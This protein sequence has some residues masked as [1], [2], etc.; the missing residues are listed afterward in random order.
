MRETTAAPPTPKINETRLKLNSP[1]KSHTKEPIIVSVNAMIVVI[2]I[3]SPLASIICS[4]RDF[5]SEIYFK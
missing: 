3:I 1:I 2:F 5:I 4:N